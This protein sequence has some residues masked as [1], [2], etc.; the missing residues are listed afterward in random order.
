ME[1]EAKELAFN[2]PEEEID[3]LFKKIPTESYFMPMDRC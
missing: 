3:Q 1:R 2:M